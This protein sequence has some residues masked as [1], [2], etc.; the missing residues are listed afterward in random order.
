MKK[1]CTIVLA[2]LLCLTAAACG[3]SG[4]LESKPVTTVAP[5]T[6]EPAKNWNVTPVE[7]AESPL[8][9]NGNHGMEI[10]GLCIK[11][12]E[13]G[14]SLVNVKEDKTTEITHGGSWIY[15][16]DGKTILYLQSRADS[17]VDFDKSYRGG[18]GLQTI[19]VYEVDDVMMYDVATDKTSKLFTKYCAGGG[20]LYFN[21]KDVYYQ[22][23]LESQIGYKNGYDPYN[24]KL[25]RFDLMTGNRELLSDKQAL[26]VKLIFVNG[27]PFLFND[28]QMYDAVGHKWLEMDVPG[29][30]LWT[31][32]GHLFFVTASSEEK[33][34]ETARRS[35]LDFDLTSG[36]SKVLYEYDIP[37][38]L[39]YVAEDF[40][41]RYVLC[42]ADI[43]KQQ[44]EYTVSY[45]ATKYRVYDLLT[46][47]TFEIDPNEYDVIYNVNSVLVS[48]IDF[49]DGAYQISYYD[50]DGNHVSFDKW[51]VNGELYEIT[52]DGYSVKTGET[53]DGEPE[54]TFVSHPLEFLKTE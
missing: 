34:E 52:P 37:E 43:T 50:D 7:E 18:D 36:T 23:I 2:L 49:G 22:D 51:K 21:N 35:I 20:I 5:S 29:N 25:Y 3:H 44:N 12:D 30:Y 48:W 31:Y 4:E 41:G 13:N 38:N 46:K 40:G 6:T 15:A 19:E 39:G 28:G 26:E 9:D 16:F 53:E 47:K 14:I 24:V 10:N 27:A 32:K 17:S 11:T 1:A 54:L 42:G 8:F 33:E 45:G